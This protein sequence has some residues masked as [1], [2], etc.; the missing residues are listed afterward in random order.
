MLRHGSNIYDKKSDLRG[1]VEGFPRYCSYVQL[2]EG[3]TFL[4][5]GIRWRKAKCTTLGGKALREMT[6]SNAAIP[7]LDM[8]DRPPNGTLAQHSRQE[9]TREHKRGAPKPRHTGSL[10]RVGGIMI[11]NAQATG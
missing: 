10:I 7:Y 1:E 9:S 5:S 4:T 8:L 3:E 6:L 11:E 2:E